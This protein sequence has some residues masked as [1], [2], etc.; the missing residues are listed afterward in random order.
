[1][2]VHP[3]QGLPLHD[4]FGSV[5]VR[6]RS[7]VPEPHGFEHVDHSDQGVKPPLTGQHSTLHG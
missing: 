2:T 6:Y 4:G 1:M 5:H 7:R 3:S